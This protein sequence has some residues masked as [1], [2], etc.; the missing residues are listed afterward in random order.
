ML[1]KSAVKFVVAAALVLA[2]AF[3]PHAGMAQLQQAAADSVISNRAEAIYADE[4]GNE[5]STVSTTITV[6]VRAVSAVV[7]TPDETAPSA[8]VAPQ[9]RITR[10]FRICNFGNTP[11][12]YTLTRAEV[13]A[14]AT[15]SALYFDTDAS[16]TLTDADTAANLNTSMSPRLAPRACI[17]VLAV[18]EVNASAPQTQLAIRLDARSN[19]SSTVNGTVEDTGTIINAVGER[20]RLTDPH[21]S[22][23]PP[24]K[25]VNDKERVTAAPG[26]TLDYTI[27]FRNSGSVVARRVLVVDELPAGLQYVAGSLRLGARALT[28][29]A[30]TDE[31]QSTSPRRF[32]VRIAEVQPDEVVKISFRAQVTSDITPGTG[33]VNTATLSGENFGNVNSSAATAIINPFGTIY[34]GRSGGAITIGGARVALVTDPTTRT[35]LATATGVGYTPN[36]PND[37]PYTTAQG[38]LFSF[39]LTPAQLAVPAT[40]YVNVT[41]PGYRSRMLEFAVRPSV[42]A[43][44][45]DAT[46]RALDEQPIAE[47][48]S[49]TLTESDVRLSG[50]ASVAL[51]IPLFELQTLEIN[52]ITD[53]QRAEIGDIVSYRV[54]VRNT[55]QAALHNVV[56]RDLLPQSFHYAQGTAQLTV[57]PDAPRAV[58]PQINGNE[59]TFNLGTLAAG[60]RASLIYR[61]RIGVNAREGD[62]TNSATASGVYASGERVS[63]NAS[64]ATVRVG[65]GVFSTRQ[66]IIGRVFE[67]K[68]GNDEF[69]AGERA[70][71]GARLYIDNGQSVVTDSEGMYSLPSVEDGSVVIAIDPVTLPRGYA[72]TD[73]GRR[74]GRSWARLLRTP[75]GG[76]TLLR[77]NFALRSTNGAS[78][79]DE[80]TASVERKDGKPAPLRAPQLA[81]INPEPAPA[82]ARETNAPRLNSLAPANNSDVNSSATDFGTGARAPRIEKISDAKETNKPS[83]DLSAGTYEL[84]SSE[85]VATVAPGDVLVVNPSEGEV[86]MSAAMQVEVRVAEDWTATLEVNGQHVGEKNIG[87]TRVDHKNKVATFTFV[88]LNV[89][90]GQNRVRAFAVSPE[91]KAGRAVELN[92][93]GRGAARR[94]EIITERDELQAGG[95]DAAT[96]RV[97]AFDQWNNPAADGQVAVIT[98]SGHFLRPAAND[99]LTTN[100]AHDKPRDKSLELSEEIAGEN[101]NAT[102]REVVLSLRGGEATV[103]LVSDNAAGVAQIQAQAGDITAKRRV[104]FTAELRPTI[105]VGLAEASIGRAAP[106]NTLRGD[107]ARVRSHIEFFYRGSVFGKNLLTLAYDSQR[108]LNRT[109]GRDRLFQAD[110]LERAYPIFGDS[111]TRFNDVESNSK[112][113]ARIDRNRSYAMFGDFEAGLT[114][115]QLAGYSR[116]LTG[117]KVHL[118]NSNGDFIAVTG[119]RPDTSF[120]RD[121]FPAG[122]IG[123]INLSYPDVLPGS[124]TVALEVRDRRNPERIISRETLLRSLD[125]NLDPLTGQLFFMRP[126]SAFD[127]DLNLVQLVVTYEHRAAGMSSGVYTGR[128]SKRFN[129]LG[130]RMGL[131]FVEQKQSEFG[132]YMLGGIDGEQTLPNRGSLKFEW[133]MSRGD[134]ATGGNIFDASTRHAGGNAYRLE[135]T[136]PLKVYEGVLRAEYARADEG[137]FN[138]FGATVAPGS[139]RTGATLDLKPGASRV[140]RLGFLNERNRT[141]NVDNSRNTFSL[142]WTET[143]SDRLHAFFGYDYRRLNDSLN[144]QQVGSNLVTVGAQYRPTDKLELSVKR[145]QNLGE[146]DPTFPSQTTIAARYK[147]SER[148]NIFFTQRLASAPIIPISDTNATGFAST[149]S[150]RETS[151]GI[152]TKLGRY[153]NVSSRYQLEN[154]INGTDS[155]AVFGLQNRLPISK[156]LSLDLGFE[157]GFHLAGE[158]TSFTG[159]S[160][161]FSYL[162]SKDLRTAARYELRNQTGGLAQLITVGAAGRIGDGLTTLA[163]FQSARS[164]F[165]GREN[166]S[167]QGTAALA[168]RPL[169]SD[170][171]ALLF[172]YTH[173]SLTQGALAGQSAVTDRSDTLSTDGLWQ[174]FKD[175]ELYGRVALKF[176]ANSREG[177]MSAS[178]LTYLAQ[179]RAQKRLRRAFDV[180]GE[181]RLMAQPVTHTTRTSVG[182][183][184]GYWVFADMRVGIGYNFTSA[185]EPGGLVVGQPRGFYFTISTKLSNIFDLFGTSA[186]G[187][188]A[189]GTTAKPQDGQGEPR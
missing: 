29:A 19:V 6:T 91:G 161:G 116:K 186:D 123:L 187:L 183:E 110:P 76:G 153:T 168:L 25:L 130:L 138:P 4:D 7:V 101:A 128:A 20:A 17:G 31:G 129:R 117:V 37:N 74:S 188:L 62:Q 120:A 147:W 78:S 68:N 122:R 167:M 126:I 84:E 137:F 115:T 189:P 156:Q 144:D 90:P 184:V 164:N 35:P 21:D 80:A 154:G 60:A 166:S 162:P 70:V 52:K 181:V 44:L 53:Q 133:A 10:L 39:A 42:V 152:E 85:V 159:G 131:S 145:E 71:E 58:E 106:E 113:Y 56:V 107:D 18:V 47:A 151:I 34:A 9:E 41:A 79:D 65:R 125:Y 104:R 32:E 155:F 89:R 158:G 55:T 87:I 165:Q 14:P 93:T 139:Q 108:S 172:S 61:T 33:A 174:P 119:A 102:L 127:Y 92:V 24:A 175:T 114:E 54:E 12:F 132:S 11:D 178:A 64:R 134:L 28:D 66:I 30:D 75:L 83:G 2:C 38:G 27:S 59:L 15:L 46:V 173:R 22:A 118:E 148:A 170:R 26:Q 97:R 73:E 45:Y 179:L 135:L 103:H 150:R 176:G 180:A 112:L 105:L 51:N 36:V 72:L 69:D 48:A 136:Q 63:T 185:T 169:K 98:T 146:A 3:A 50:L 5:F 140:I 157:H 171:A 88:G 121:V 111:S 182:A 143:F 16:G 99:A 160:F 96:L 100:D 67:D 1:T 8:A 142:L 86:V 141:A 57:S 95:R 23:L 82:T 177:L 49:F 94:L 81:S 77:Q 163:R 109:Q 43:G 124:E 13:T 149:G 40:Y